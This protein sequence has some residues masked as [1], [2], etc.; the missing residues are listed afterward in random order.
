MA[1]SLNDHV[2]ECLRHAEDCVQEAASQTN[3]KRRREYL[4]IGACWLKLCYELSDQLASKPP[5]DAASN[6][7]LH[8]DK[9]SPI[10]A[11]AR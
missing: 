11:A 1:E 2:R 3:P 4:S 7:P 8:L 6:Q 5:V 9:P 10:Y